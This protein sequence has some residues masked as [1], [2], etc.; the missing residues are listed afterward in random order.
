MKT[1]MLKLGDIW[2]NFWIMLGN[3]LRRGS[4]KPFGYIVLE[5]RGSLP[6]FAPPP[7]PWQRLPIPWLP[8]P[9]PRLSLT[10]LRAILER[11][12]GDPRPQGIII[13][14]DGLECGWA[15]AQSLRQA[16]ARFRKSGKP[17]IAEASGFSA[18]SYFVACAADEI[19]APPS[20]VWAVGGLRIEAL[21]LKDAL[22]DWGI[23]ADVIAVSPYKTAADTLSRADMS[24]EQREML[25]WILDTQFEEIVN[26]I[27][28]GRG[29]TA[30]QVKQHIDNMPLMAATAAEHKLI[31]AAL[32]FD[33]LAGH[34]GKDGEP[35]KLLRWRAARRR[36]RR[37]VRWRSGK[38][39]GVVS[40]EG[41]IVA[42]RSRRSPLPVP[43][44]FIGSTQ[45]GSDTVAQALRSAEANPRIAAVVFYVDSR[46]GSAL[47]SDLIWREVARLR[48][49]KPVVVCMG[50]AAASGGYYVAAA[51]N[52]IVA[53]PLTLTGSIGVIFTKVA[54]LGLYR[55]FKANPVSL[56]RGARAG[57]WTDS[58]PYSDEL[59]DAVKQHTIEI[60]EQ[61]KTRVTGGREITVEQLEPLAGGRV[62]LGRQALDHA[63]VDALGDLE[64][65]IDKAKALAELP[66]NRWTP[67]IW[68]LGGKGGALPPSFP[69]SDN[70]GDL[71][72]RWHEWLAA[73]TQEQVWLVAPF[74]IEIK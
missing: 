72:E 67:T 28:A 39:I 18:R 63:L 26:A 17:V 49:K 12:A 55:R 34:L 5:L 52:W 14:L 35:A 71:L 57:L 4:R 50:N 11:I 20:A 29:L 41:L 33:E 65:A 22:N 46:G 69:N 10:A 38:A 25:N 68:V 40:L 45:A 8:R 73:F 6:E 31:D 16:L 43:L 32:Y 27:V 58:A 24:S 48:R 60:Y 56:Q 54:T 70:G 30:K 21:F 7:P 3:L 53:Q 74:E 59:R 2:R 15:T 62:W 19:I 1:I 51:A 42:G 13:R 23:E 61:F 37:P 36:L 44:P 9:T 66:A 47:A 64:D